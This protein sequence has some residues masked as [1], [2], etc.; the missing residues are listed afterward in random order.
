MKISFTGDNKETAL[1]ANVLK[2]LF[3]QNLQ[4]DQMNWSVCSFPDL[5]NVCGKGQELTLEERIPKVV[6]RLG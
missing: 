3:V 5:S 6:I 2:L 1:G 4:M